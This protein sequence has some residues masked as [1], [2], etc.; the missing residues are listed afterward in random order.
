MKEVQRHSKHMSA[1]REIRGQSVTR[2]YKFWLTSKEIPVASP[3]PVEISKY[4][5]KVK[6]ISQS[7]LVVAALEH[8]LPIYLASTDSTP[9][10]LEALINTAKKIKQ[11]AASRGVARS[12]KLT[13]E[14]RSEIA[15]KAADARWEGKNTL[16]R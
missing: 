14:R 2:K 12:I 6:G 7:A 13:P 15:K 11:R 10:N 4:P 1:I 3:P 9:E 5:L 8:N 16:P